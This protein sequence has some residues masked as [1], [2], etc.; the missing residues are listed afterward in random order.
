MQSHFTNITVKRPD[1]LGGGN[2]EIARLYPVTILFG[3]NG[4]G[5]SLLL[6]AW[7]DIAV[8]QTHYVVPERTGTLEF[9]AGYVEQELSGDTRRGVSSKNYLA[10][11]RQHIIARI[12]AFLVARGASREGPLPGRLEELEDLISLLLPDFA[13]QLVGLNPPFILTRSDSQQVIRS[14]DDLS[15]GEAQLLTMGLDILTIAA[16]WDIQKADK[17]LVLVDEPDA[18]IHPDLQVRFADFVIQLARRFDLQVV[19]ATHSTTLLAAIGQF[20]TEQAGVVYLDRSKTEFN[21][22]AF[23]ASLK[24]VASCLGGHALMGPLF[25]VPLLL[26][27]GDDDYRIW[28]QVPRH[29]QTNFAVIPCHGEEIKI[30]QKTL[31]LIFN[32]LRGSEGGP[33]G[34]AL[35]DGDKGLPQANAVCPQDHVKFLK[36]NCL[37][38]EN[39]YLTDQVLAL[40]GLSWEEA[41]SK[42]VAAAKTVNYGEKS[43]M[44]AAANKWSRQHEDLKAVIAEIAD[45]LDEKHVHWTVRVGKAIGSTKPNGQLREFLGE[46]LIEA[47][48]P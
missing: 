33:A 9:Q 48:W 10:D 24:E 40:L 1:F 16:T 23:T 3:K 4:S 18:H 21:T 8:D 17:R 29:H 35:L 7:R 36:L 15:S 37:E 34:F 20:G 43:S 25:G 28:S 47:L 32:S 12:Q 27:E 39:L 6:R 19:I 26:V 13:V 11:Y 31:E 41:V 42:L 2:W 44:L 22:R 30:Y 45:I 14:V 5:K 46:C 38:S